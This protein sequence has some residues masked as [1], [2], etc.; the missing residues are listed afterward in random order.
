VLVV[1]LIFSWLLWW[2]PRELAGALLE[3]LDEAALMHGVGGLAIGGAMVL[4]WLIKRYIEG[5]SVLSAH[6]TA[7]PEPP[8]SAATCFELAKLLAS[9]SLKSSHRLTWRADWLAWARAGW[10]T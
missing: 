8:W 2:R 1:L 3:L 10:Q 4:A 6:L 7:A 5:E 9:A